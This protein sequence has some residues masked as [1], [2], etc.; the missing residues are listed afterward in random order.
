M[1][2]PMTM[3]RSGR[4]APC[5][6]ACSPRLARPLHPVAA[7]SRP[8]RNSIL[9]TRPLSSGGAFMSR[10]LT[11]TSK[12]LLPALLGLALLA[13]PAAA[14]TGYPNR[15]VHIVV[16]ST[17]GGGTDTFARLIGQHLASTLG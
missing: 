13:G 4:V 7:R 10:F 12:P 3:T 5:T 9:S 11:S 17:P 2:P 1:P 14:Q 16:P 6:I 15:P 8:R